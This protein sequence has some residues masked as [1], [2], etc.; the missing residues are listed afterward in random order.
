MSSYLKNIGIVQRLQQQTIGTRLMILTSVILITVIFSLG[1]LYIWHERE[2]RI[3]ES[4]Q[5]LDKSVE[6]QALSINEWFRDHANTVATVAQLYSVRHLNT[7]TMQYDFN[8]SLT[9]S[10][11]FNGYVFVN[12]AGVTE[13][14]T[15]A[16]PGTDVSNREYFR[17]GIQGKPAITDI[18]IGRA[19]GEKVIIFSQPV[20]NNANSISGIVFATVSARKLEDVIQ[21]F[22]F[23][24]TGR[25]YLIDKSAHIIAHTGSNGTGSESMENNEGYWRAKS[26]LS[27]ADRYINHRG[28]EVIGAYQ[29]VPDRDWVLLVEIDEQEVLLPLYI[30][31]QKAVIGSVIILLFALVLTW[32]MSRSIQRPI[33]MLLSASQGAQYGDYSHTISEEKF[34][35]APVEIRGLC[36]AFNIMLGTINEHIALLY[37]RNEALAVAENKYRKLSTQDQLTQIHNRTYFE[38]EVSRLQSLQQVPVGVVICDVDG[39]KLIND[40][41]GHKAGDDLIRAAANSIVQSFSAHATVARIGGDEFAVLM[42]DAELAEVF[43]GIKRL[44]STVEEHNRLHPELPLAISTG[45]A[46]AANLPLKLEDIISEADNHMYQEKNRNRA[47]NRQLLLTTL[48]QTAGKNDHGFFDHIEGVK[49]WA[50]K[51]GQA[52]LLDDQALRQL[53]LAAHYHDIGKVG[54]PREILVKCGQLTEDEWAQIRAHAELGGRLAKAVAELLPVADYITSHHERW[55]GSGYP[56]K[57]KGEGIPLIS[58]IVA[59]ADSYDAMQRNTPY[60]KAVSREDA[61][62]EIQAHAGKQ[63]DPR[64]VS[65]LLKTVEKECSI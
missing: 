61:N 51:L 26:G 40:T 4:K 42:P 23:G 20:I 45:G 53:E 44:R 50:L 54:V 10:R 31:I 13:V 8:A 22:E 16:P 28:T 36:N 18:L 55:D 11:D 19:T 9:S 65:L 7:E 25:A 32:L 62:R 38:D 56:D 47:H 37:D 57:I 12:K 24:Q 2:L 30:L 33:L 39:L 52:L 34:S 35:F 48:M 3:Q 14:D 46:V 17:L 49:K 58:R 1:V 29:W 5:F 64:L 6:E 43:A 41:L 27:G 59:I 21:E 63:F 60:R 15:I